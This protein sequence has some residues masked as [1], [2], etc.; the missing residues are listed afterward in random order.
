MGLHMDG[1]SP[2]VL[3][4]EIALHKANFAAGRSHRPSRSGRDYR[5]MLS[6]HRQELVKSARWDDFPQ[7]GRRFP[8]F[9]LPDAHGGK[10]SFGDLLGSGPIAIV[11]YRGG[12]CPYCDM[13]LRAYQ[14][15]V[16]PELAT[17]GAHLVAIS[18]QV[19]DHSLI[20][21]ESAELDFPLL[22]DLGS[23]LAQELHL[24]FSAPAEYIEHLDDTDRD[25]RE[26]NGVTDGHFQLVMPST[27]VLDPAG[28]IHF[29]DV[30]P[31]FTTRTE[32]ADIVAAIE[33]VGAS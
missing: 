14:R 12:W 8:D 13:A 23:V 16:V 30:H 7:V 2:D 15:H 22:S 6:T 21:E 26:I 25:L 1:I 5:S 27:F 17:F 33:A 18:P 3:A 28:I 11:F 20:T 29:A 31:D 19:P 24:A 10:V 9:N 4:N 32:P